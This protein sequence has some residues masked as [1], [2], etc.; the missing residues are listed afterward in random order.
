MNDHQNTER[1]NILVLDGCRHILLDVY[2]TR[3]RDSDRMVKNMEVKKVSVIRYV[4]TNE[5]RNVP[6]TM[7]STDC[8]V[9][10]R[11]LMTN[12]NLCLLT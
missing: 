9:L 6:L 7:E 10:V 5:A 8:R 12:E 11:P 3:N 1:Y 2:Q 4:D